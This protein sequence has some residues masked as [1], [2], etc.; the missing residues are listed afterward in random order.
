MTLYLLLIYSSYYFLH[1]QW[2]VW[3]LWIYLCRL[4][5]NYI[6]TYYAALQISEL[7]LRVQLTQFLLAPSQYLST[8]NLGFCR[9]LILVAFIAVSQ[10][11][12]WSSNFSK[13]PVSEVAMVPCSEVAKHLSTKISVYDCIATNEVGFWQ[14]L[15]G[16][17]RIEDSFPKPKWP[18]SRS[19]YHILLS[20]VFLRSVCMLYEGWKWSNSFST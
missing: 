17:W 6:M 9:W 19:Q 18:P 8:A 2:C 5:I 15:E 11:A 3:C 7:R 14:T 16:W 20:H 13:Q 4:L 12:T 1:W 10:P